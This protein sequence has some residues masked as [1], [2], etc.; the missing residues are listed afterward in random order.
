MLY[1]REKYERK[2]PMEDLKQIAA[3]NITELRRAAGMTQ[4][5]LAARLN[6]SDKAVSKWERGESLPD[7][8]VFKQ[9]ADLFQVTVDSL[10][11]EKKPVRT[12]REAYYGRELRNRAIILGISLL[13]VCLA[14]TLIFVILNLVAGARAIH[15]LA[16]LYAVPVCVIVWLVFNTLW[17]NRRRNFLIISLLVWSV[18]ACVHLTLLQFGFNVWLIYLLGIPGQA[19][20]LLW[21]QLKFGKPV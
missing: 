7:V 9:L 10:L 13:L 2:M 5:E 16:F 6:Y 18:L 11:S 15:W 20:I 19:I 12:E 3:K 21:S 14:A 8:A 4:M 1:M 17:F